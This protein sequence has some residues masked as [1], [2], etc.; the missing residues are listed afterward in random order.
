MR[1]ALIFVLLAGCADAPYEWTSP[2]CRTMTLRK[3]QQC[4]VQ[5]FY[6]PREGKVY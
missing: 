5:V 6:Q 3:G 1:Y 2:D 4:E